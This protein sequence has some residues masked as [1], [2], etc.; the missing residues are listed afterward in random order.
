MSRD[1][2]KKP[3]TALILTPSD[4]PPP[5][6]PVFTGAELSLGSTSVRSI[7]FCEDVQE[8]VDFEST[9]R[10]DSTL[11]RL[12]VSQAAG[13]SGDMK[14]EVDSFHTDRASSSTVVSSLQSPLSTPRVRM[15]SNESRPGFQRTA[16]IK[17]QKLGRFTRQGSFKP[18]MHGA[19]GSVKRL[20]G[21]QTS[22]SDSTK[23]APAEEVDEELMAARQAVQ[24]VLNGARV[25]MFPP[26]DGRS[27]TK[28]H[29]VNMKILA[30]GVVQ[31][32]NTPSRRISN[33]RLSRSSGSRTNECNS[34]VS[35]SDTESS[36]AWQ[37]TLTEIPGSPHGGPQRPPALGALGA[38][39]SASE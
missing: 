25:R 22:S 6:P 17:R 18:G 19:V 14:A 16:S 31:W 10:L 8:P 20:L 39:A 21:R 26:D 34:G 33:L 4:L 15:P 28:P 9:A 3:A 36:E 1:D 7:S 35:S 32:H 29:V 12:R 30:V 24:F 37:P 23:E 5:P 27:A 2:E 38:G 11:Q 13:R